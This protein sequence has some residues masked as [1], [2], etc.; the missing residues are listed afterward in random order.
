MTDTPSYRRQFPRTQVGF[1]V[2]VRVDGL[3]KRRRTCGRLVV[4]SA[5]GA[6]LE[7]DEGYPIGTLLRMGFELATPGEIDCRAIVRRAIAGKGV[8][9]EFLDI[10]PGDRERI[11]AFVEQL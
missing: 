11:A 2:D 3:R 5:R 4:L 9:V 7:L 6:L 1:D 10:E 8:G